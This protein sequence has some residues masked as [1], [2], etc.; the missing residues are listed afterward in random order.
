MSLPEPTAPRP[1]SGRPVRRRWLLAARATAVA[2]L[3][4]SFACRQDMFNQ[5]RLKP[6][7]ESDFYRDG[8]SARLPVPDTVPRSA[9]AADTALETGVGQDGRFVSGLPVP[10]TRALLSRGRERFDIFCAP[11]HGRVGDGRGMIV[12]RGFK[13]PPS[14]HIE[15]LRRQPIGYLFDVATNGFG[16]M[17]GYRSQVPPADRWAIAAYIRAL[18]LSQ[19][20]EIDLLPAGDRRAIESAPGG[21]P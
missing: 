9:G 7:A 14:Y 2:A 18:Q 4:V 3:V 12:Q 1:G 13:A 11:C 17:S 15:R 20:A 21:T 16:Q 8:M 19:H 5:P 10:L 6:L